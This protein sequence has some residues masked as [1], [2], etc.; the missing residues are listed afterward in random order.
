MSFCTICGAPLKS[1]VCRACGHRQLDNAFVEGQPDKRLTLVSAE[2]PEPTYDQGAS[3]AFS[4]ILD[5]RKRRNFWT[6]QSRIGRVFIFIFLGWLFLALFCLTFGVIFEI[7]EKGPV[8][9]AREAASMALAM[10]SLASLTAWF[11]TLGRS[12]KERWRI[13]A[14]N[15]GRPG[16]IFGV[17]FFV[18]TFLSNLLSPT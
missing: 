12:N 14:G 10:V 6:V 8:N 18:L 2:F 4:G 1:R 5:K 17:G 11:T 15:E 3:T 7:Q 16:L 13:L 9:G